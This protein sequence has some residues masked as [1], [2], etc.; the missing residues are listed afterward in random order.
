L[1]GR[2]EQR[3]TVS[4]L[5]SKEIK[6][7]MNS[8]KQSD[9]NMVLD[10]FWLSAVSLFLEL[11]IIRWLSSEVRA[12]SIFKNFPLIASYIGLGFGYMK[13]SSTGK[14]FRLFPL[15]LLVFVILLATSNWTGLTDIMMPSTRVGGGLFA[16]W[17][18]WTHPPA[19]M[20]EQPMLYTALS[21]VALF[22]IVILVA[23]TMAG[24]G[25]KL[26]SLF[27]KDAPLK[28]YLYN[29]FGSVVGIAA[30]SLLS[31][32]CTPP[33]VWLAVGCLAAVYPMRK[34]KVGIALLAASVLVAAAVPVKKSLGDMNDATTKAEILWS[35][36]HRVEVAPLKL[37]DTGQSIGYQVAV[38]KAFFQQPLNLS[39]QFLNSQTPEERKKLEDFRFD[40]YEIPYSFVKAKRV[41]I[42]GSGTGNDVASALK[43]GA[44]HVDAVEIDPMMVELGKRLHPEH[45][46]DSPKVT[47]YIND[48]RAFLRQNHD[49][50]DLVITG[51]LDS[52]AVAGNSLSVRLD[53]YV[54]TV[55]GM[56]DAI[57]HVAPGGLYCITYCAPVDFLSKRLIANLREA[58][59]EKPLP[60]KKAN[61]AIWHLYTPPTSA[62]R[63]HLAELQP[64]GFKDYSDVNTDEVRTSTDDW[65]FLYLSPISFDPIYLTIVALILLLAWFACGQSIRTNASASRWKLFFLGSAF[66]LLELGII[67]RLS[68]VFGTTWIV[69]SICIFAVLTAIILSNILIMQKPK[70][71]PSTAMYAGLIGTLAV[72]YVVPIQTF[73][74]MG[75][76]VGGSIAALLSAIPVFFA[77]MIFSTAFKDEEQPSI[78]LAFN[79]LGSVVGGLTEYAASYTGIRS[80]LLISAFFY[81]CSFAFGKVAESRKKQGF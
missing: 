11:V 53:D 38:N 15:F 66:M 14:L 32:F 46:Y 70:I 31:F 47:V 34:N 76:W 54:Y 5:A 68:L 80:L 52:H 50:Y 26:G 3:F 18:D 56:K 63:A 77:G 73:N 16:N 19:G 20:I 7:R 60:F 42:M 30:F 24:L 28:S 9:K 62:T 37:G 33:P 64:Q 55:D 1:E 43:L 71:M 10:L 44:E 13:E 45:P 39:D 40:Q 67:D 59:P 17:W 29:L 36:Y 12:F 4:F 22:S 27:D 23:T 58:S 81:L 57:A 35:P 8:D 41:L 61:G 75:M 6:K 78:G 21:L 2:V 72:L 74:S 65:P 69:N 51:F 48:A 49:K 79:M 25:Q